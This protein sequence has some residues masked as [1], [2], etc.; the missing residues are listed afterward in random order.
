MKQKKIILTIVLSVIFCSIKPA[1]A[2]IKSIKVNKHYGM[3]VKSDLIEITSDKII[4]TYMDTSGFSETREETISNTKWNVIIGKI[5]INIFNSL[6]ERIECNKSVD[7][8][9]HLIMDGP[10]MSI[11]IDD[12]EKIKRVSFSIYNV[13][14]PA[15]NPLIG[16]I[17]K[18]ILKTKSITESEGIDREMIQKIIF[19]YNKESQANRTSISITPQKINYHNSNNIFREGIDVP[20]SFDLWNSIINKIDLKKLNSMPKRKYMPNPSKDTSQPNKYLVIALK[21]DKS[22]TFSFYEHGQIPEI[23]PLVKI[24]KKIEME[25]GHYYSLQ[26]NLR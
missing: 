5:D 10:S 9:I 20:I 4:H 22:R 6:P 7:H 11:E 16:Q 2:E 14:V 3:T 24:I 19:S 25:S 1:N 8:C 18:I 23:D 21:G 12:G 15:L 13:E 26:K 17:N